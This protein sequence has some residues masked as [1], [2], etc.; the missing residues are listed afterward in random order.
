M[1][2]NYVR[3]SP[4][5]DEWSV[6]FEVD[7]TDRHRTKTVPNPLGWYH[8]PASMNKTKALRALLECMRWKHLEEIDRLTQSLEKLEFELRRVV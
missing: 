6:V 7:P 1:K 5:G 8:Y 4:D 3:V 2:Y